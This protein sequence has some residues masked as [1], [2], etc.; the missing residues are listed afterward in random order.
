MKPIRYLEYVGEEL[1][2]RV[3]W[4]TGDASAAAQAISDLD[5]RREAG[6]NVIIFRGA[7]CWFVGPDPRSTVPEME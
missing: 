1:A 4:V 6:E 3:A 2:R 7:N 5:R